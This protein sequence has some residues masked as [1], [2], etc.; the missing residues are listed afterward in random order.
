MPPFPSDFQFSQ[1]TLQ[2]YAD[3]QR[4]FELRY[5][6]EQAWPAVEVEPLLDKEN[7]LRRGA[8]FHR[9]VQQHLLGLPAEKMIGADPELGVWWRNFLANGLAGLP[10]QRH[11]EKLLSIR[12]AGFPLVARYDLIALEGGKRAVIVDWKTAHALPRRLEDR[13]QTRIYRY[14]L[15]RAGA[16][17]NGGQQIAPEQVEM[18]YWFANFPDQPA[19]IAY[20]A[21]KFQA[22]EAYLQDMMTTIATQGD[23][24]L[25]DDPRKCAYCTYRSLCGRG[26]KAGSLAEWEGEDT[27]PEEPITELE[28]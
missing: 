4:R 26:E 5:L 10:Q 3:C 16:R 20:D 12:L 18:V 25:T 27:P 11:A 6:Q 7:F 24:P 8:V 21:H 22:D 15:V 1:S 13:L 28:F 14:V 9:M 17:L 23:F 19:R 2:D